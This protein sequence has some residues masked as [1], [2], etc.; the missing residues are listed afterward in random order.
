MRNH[1]IFVTI[2]TPCYN[3][4]GFIREAVES[5][6][7]QDYP[8]V[9]HLIVDGASTDD[10]LKVLAAY[11][12]LRVVS[13]PDE[14]MYAAINKGLLLARGDVIGLLNSDDLYDI[15]VF[16][17][18][19]RH[20]EENDLL[21]AVVGAAEVFRDQLQTRQV[22]RINKWIEPD[23]QWF[24]LIEGAPVTNAWFFRR[25]V[26]DR[27]G[28][29]DTR[30]RYSADRE[31]LIRAAL[32][33][34]NYQP[35]RRI[36]YHYRQHEESFTISP[37]DAR[38]SNRAQTRM[39]VLQEALALSED[40][41]MRTDLPPVVRRHLRRFHDQR[42]YALT[43]TALYHK[44]PRLAFATMAKGLKVNPAW[45]FAFVK[46]AARRLMGR[47]AAA[48]DHPQISANDIPGASV[49]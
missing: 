39:K 20:F 6:L 43:A 32:S 38:S 9:E 2:I 1:P 21:D 4:A 30:F 47:Q 42:A 23:E 34:L 40:F 48:S 31:F 28:N 16:S 19:I 37:E 13:E 33:G 24:R 29:F 10:T 44:S 26:F 3:R 18:V 5:V 46:Y 36:L 41:L 12:H 27:I 17:E 22:V 49:R 8:A 7:G 14:G 11:P 45:G 35:I 25:Q 15:N